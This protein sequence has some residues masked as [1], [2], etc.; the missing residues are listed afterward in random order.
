[1]ECKLQG[2]GKERY[3]KENMY[4]QVVDRQISVH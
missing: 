3:E 4:L 1:M 2:V